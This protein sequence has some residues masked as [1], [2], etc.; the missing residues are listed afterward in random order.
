MKIELEQVWNMAKIGEEH[1]MFH[2]VFG[3]G[4]AGVGKRTWGMCGSH[5]QIL[6]K[7]MGEGEM[8]GVPSIGVPISKIIKIKIIMIKSQQ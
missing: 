2:Q 8:S 1:T 4:S 7:F 5:P 3:T 6:G